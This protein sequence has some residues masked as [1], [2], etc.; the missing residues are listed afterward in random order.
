MAEENE[1]KL[2]S[3]TPEK[4]EKTRFRLNDFDG[5]LDLLLCLIKKNDVNIYDIPI[6]SIT[7]QYI[8]YL[9]YNVSADL[10]DLTE[11]YNMA[12]TL[13]YIKSNMLLPVEM[14]LEDEIED[15]RQELVD[16]L[17][18]YQKFK[19]LSDLMEEKE[20]ESEWVFERK[21]IQHSLPFEEES[22]WEKVDTWDLCR[23]FSRIMSN[24]SAERILNIHEDVSI[25]D[26]ITLMHELLN[27]KKYCF[28]TDLIGS[29]GKLLDVVCA[30]MALLEAVKFKMVIV[31]QNRM[32]G[33]I[34]ICPVESTEEKRA[35]LVEEIK[36]GVT[37]G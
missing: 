23:T 3:S 30:F 8:K 4:K 10:G 19:K 22:M 32:F 14:N 17:I 25:D 12:A 26:K 15:P 5:P 31:F 18:E 29:E 33:D 21:K 6:A 1:F 20:F 2:E 16:K 37:V 11:F 35:A 9:E 34:K 24:Y 27:E 28:F 13:L 7:E 36:D